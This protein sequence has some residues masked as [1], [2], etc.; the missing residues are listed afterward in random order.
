MHQF[1]I[2]RLLQVI[3]TLLGVS[4]LV[5]SMMHLVPGSPIDYMFQGVT[6][7]AA[8]RQAI[9]SQLG[10]D[11]PLPVQYLRW[12]SKTARGDLGEAIFVQRPVARIITDELSHT[13]RLAVAGMMLTIVAGVGLGTMSALFHNTGLEAA[14]QVVA[15]SG[16]SI[17]NFWL[18]LMLI[19]VFA[20]RLN[21]LPIFGDPSI[22]VLL[23]PAFVVGFRSSAMISRLTHSGLLEVLNED[24]VRTAR[25]KGL[26][27]RLVVGRHALRN[28]LIPVVTYLGLQFGQLLGG[29]VI[30]ETVFARRGIGS[31]TVNAILQ[32]DLPLAQGTVMFVSVVYV[33]V[34]L[35]VDI[36]YAYI[37]PRVRYD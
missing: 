20:V 7:T 2:R 19:Y 15:L 25:A 32:R 14:L 10:L 31:L 37:D 23:L 17:P 26:N 30:V 28:A 33:L 8:E 6:L 16:L 22:R 9:E 18:G 3:P 34:N 24:Y 12:L 11:D 4:I 27:E 35:V 29:A 5:F 1:V 13:L 21:W 36:L